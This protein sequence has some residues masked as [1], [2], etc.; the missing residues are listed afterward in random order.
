MRSALCLSGI[1]GKLYTEKSGY[2][3]E[4]DID[5]RIGHHFYKKNII[6]VNE[7]V[8]VFVFCWDIKYE[9]EIIDLY[10]PKES[11]FIDQIQFKHN[12][13]KLNNIESRWYGAQQVNNLK[14]K[15]ENDNN[16]KYDFVM[17][18]RFD[19]GIFDK[20]IFNSV[21]DNKALHIPR[22]NPPDMTRPTILDYWYFSNSYNMD[23]I[24]NFYDHWKDYGYGSPHRDLYQWPTDNDIDV[25]MLNNFQDSEKGNGNTDIIRAVYDNCGYTDKKFDINNINKLRKYP[26][27]TRF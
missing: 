17:W 3:W 11:L 16:F 10:Q 18:S 20:L 2:K 12:E 9:N 24:N 7:N 25:T 22:S 26:R 19:V 13:Q 4:N 23:I 5:F 6:D 1:V 27:G 8:D 14:V 15:Y 21:Q